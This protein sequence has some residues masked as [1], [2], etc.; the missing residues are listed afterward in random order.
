M[1]RS[2][3]IIASLLARVRAHPIRTGLIGVGAL[4]I[5]GLP[6]FFV[7]K[8]VA[9]SYAERTCVRELTLLPGIQRQ[10][11]DTSYE[12]TFDGVRSVGGFDYAATSVCFAPVEIPSRG[13]VLIATGPW[14]SWVPPQVYTLAVGAEPSV[15][16]A[17]LARPIPTTKPVEVALDQPDELHTYSLIVDKIHEI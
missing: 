9:F 12:V 11:T 13:D 5:V 16:V 14:G 1:Q 4:L 8:T 15:D 2:K 3:V 7:P 6:W 10:A 17:A